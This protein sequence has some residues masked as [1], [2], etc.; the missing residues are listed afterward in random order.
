MLG[1][2]WL[3][4]SS[5]RFRSFKDLKLNVR[6][7]VF[8][9][10]AIGSSA[11]VSTQLEPAFVLVWLLCIYVLLGILEWLLALPKRIRQGVV[12]RDSSAPPPA[13]P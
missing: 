13:S 3:M 9:I 5:V 7:V 4:V 1:L 11:V 6:S 2:A 10:F 12:Q 8:V